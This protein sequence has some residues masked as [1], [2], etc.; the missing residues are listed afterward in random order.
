[1][2]F[3]SIVLFVLCSNTAIACECVTLPLAYRTQVSEAIFLG[4]IVSYGTNSIELHVLETFKGQL[5][6]QITIHT[7]TSM[8][9]YF[10]P[11]VGQ[12]GSR[13]L[14]FMNIKDGQQNVSQCLGSAP[15]SSAAE[16][17][18]FLRTAVP[19]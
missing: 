11:G 3:I 2:R 19:K 14:I 13:F 12:P 16:E 15:E 7:G 6:A 10:F 8:C 18:K 9:D 1:M 5:N 17:I 4:E